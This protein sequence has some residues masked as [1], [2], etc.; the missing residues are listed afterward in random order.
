MYEAL[1]FILV[2]HMMVKHYQQ[3][4][5][6]YKIVNVYVFRVIKYEL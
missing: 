6:C 4:S 1:T 5:L 2:F 3:G